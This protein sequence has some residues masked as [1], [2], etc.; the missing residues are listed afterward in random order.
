MSSVEYDTPEL[1]E[2]YDAL[3]DP[4]YKSGVKLVDMLGLSEG[5]RV[6]DLGCGTGRLT[7]YAAGKVGPAGK[8][9]GIDPAPPRIEIARKKLASRSP[10]NIEFNVR[11][12]DDLE[13]FA[14]DQFHVAYLSSVL[15]WIPDKNTT[16]RELFRILK[17][18]GRIGIVSED[19]KNELPI[20]QAIYQRL[21]REPYAGQFG[22]I[23][24][25]KK[26][27]SDIRK[28]ASS[29]EIGQI[30]RMTGFQS[31]DI[32][33]SVQRI[34]W[35]TAA[36]FVEFMD[37]SS[38]GPYRKYLSDSILEE[39]RKDIEDGLEKIMTPKGLILTRNPVYIIAKK[40]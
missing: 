26:S 17:P 33:A 20:E 21:T 6:L 13:G 18:G 11:G 19:G 30:L 27:M 7:L 24:D 32:Q 2:K 34:T 38:F 10:T 16:I 8:V 5:D 37:A 3:S 35:A 9:V 28:P 12:S 1:A 39:I 36:E 15:N 25:I 40:P 31:V 29:E 23:K 4:Q 22:D 14:R